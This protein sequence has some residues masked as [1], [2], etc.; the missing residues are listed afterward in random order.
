MNSTLES[1]SLL[2]LTPEGS[3]LPV[4]RI[5]GIREVLH[6]DILLSKHN[7]IWG[8]TNTADD[9]VQLA[10]RALFMEHID[11]LGIS[12]LLVQVLSSPFHPAY[13]IRRS[14]LS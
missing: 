13:E 11:C 8:S 14:F 5:L 1:F 12:E 7:V 3:G 2:W 9:V 6:A 4:V 10:E